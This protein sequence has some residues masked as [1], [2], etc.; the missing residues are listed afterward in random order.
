MSPP[1]VPVTTI[2]VL[3]V[4]MAVCWPELEAW[5]SA[6][7]EYAALSVWTPTAGLGVTLN[8]AL[9]EDAPALVGMPPS[10]ARLIV[11]V[12]VVPLE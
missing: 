11:P 6:S 12:G 7:P 1:L 2:V 8:I 5:F 9:P 3:P 4:R 10:T